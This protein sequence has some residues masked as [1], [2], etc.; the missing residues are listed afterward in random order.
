M[1]SHGMAWRGV[2][3]HRIAW[4]GVAWRGVAWHGMAWLG[5]VW[6]GVAWHSTAYAYP[7]MRCHARSGNNRASH[8]RCD[9]RQSRARTRVAVRVQPAYLQSGD[10]APSLRGTRAM[11][12][13]AVLQ[14][15]EHWGGG[16]R[17]AGGRPQ[18]MGEYLPRSFR[19][20]ALLLLLL[21][22]VPH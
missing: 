16:S 14:V 2:A 5:V 1:A 22:L 12:C 21:L 17:G 13:Y 10:F 9:A 8:K 3:S 15:R 7:L 11:L 18:R 19:T 20:R 4:R 6:R